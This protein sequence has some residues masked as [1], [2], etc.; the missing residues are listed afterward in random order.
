MFGTR[1][2]ARDT[3]HV[4]SNT[5]RKSRFWHRRD[6]DRVAGG[7]KVALSNPNTTHQGRKHAK[8]ELRKMGQDTHVPF[9]TKVKRTLGIRST[10]R[11]T[12]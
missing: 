2:Q 11:R 8:H 1:R 10:T 4:S 9:M 7:Y 3:H 5:S 6:K 12:N